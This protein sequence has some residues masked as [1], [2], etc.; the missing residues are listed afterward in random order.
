M[1]LNATNAKSNLRNILKAPQ[2]KKNC[3]AP[4]AKANTLKKYFLFLE[5]QKQ[6]IAIFPLRVTRR[7]VVVVVVRWVKRVHQGQSCNVVYARIY[8]NAKGTK[9]FTE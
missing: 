6:A 3:L 8:L 9:G 1:N 7:V 5:L 4:P 2:K